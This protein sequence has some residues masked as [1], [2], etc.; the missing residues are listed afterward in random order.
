[1]G[2]TRS[3]LRLVELGPAHYDCSWNPQRKSVPPFVDWANFH[4]LVVSK[5]VIGYT[6]NIDP[7]KK[8]IQRRGV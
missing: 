2:Q 5:P 1:M 7:N 6:Q 4:T 3:P 8:A